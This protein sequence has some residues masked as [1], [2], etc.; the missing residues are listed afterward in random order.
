MFRAAN[1]PGRVSNALAMPAPTGGI[2]D[3]DPLSNM[4]DK[5]VIDAINWYMDTGL[6][7]V[8]PG[9]QEWC[10]G[11]DGAV[12]TIMSFNAQ[13]GSFKKFASTDT[14]IYNISTSLPSPPP[15]SVTI[16]NGFWSSTGFATSAGQYL[17]ACNGA[18]TVL[19]DGTSWIKFTEVTTPSGP[20]QIKGISPSQFKYVIAHKGRL[21]FIQK[22]SM[23]AWYLPIDSVGGEAKPF[24]LGGIFRRGGFLQILARWSSDTGEGLDDRLIFITSTGEIASYQGNDPS[25]AADWLLDS[26]FF[27]APPLSDRA[28]TEY[29]G[30]LLLLCRRGLVPLSSLITGS[31]TEVLYSGALT[32]RI[33]RT[34]IRLTQQ[35]SPPFPPEVVLN[36]DAAWTVINLYDPLIPGQ[37]SFNR[38]LSD[39]TNAPIQL[40][41]NFLTGAWGKFN[42]PIRTMRQI[43]Q[44]FFMGSDNGNVYIVTPDSF[45]DNVAR[46]GSAGTPIAAYAMGAYTYLQNPTA[47]KHA[48][49]IRP[50][51]QADVKPSFLMRVLPDFRLD[52][53]LE[54]PPPNPAIGNARWDISRWDLANWAGLENV[55]RPWVSANQLGYAFAWQLKVST[56]SALGL[57][58]VEWVWENGGYV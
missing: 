24:F 58:A 21:W 7:V 18:E 13:D 34:L 28:V 15:E 45:V 19:Y 14:H 4:E 40:V 26:I 46:D 44:T 38:V 25:N 31:A 11:L 23:T 55:Y 6:M 9:Y 8:R 57:A 1:M 39:G 37:A 47:N 22:N 36:N 56:S 12:K 35:Q 51:F 16:A 29:G 43:D 27:V 3:L 17:I 54:S 49:M 10:T 42:Y 48:K 50:V 2:N 53:F 32:R 30:D 33:S 5:F 41:M 52:R 20:G